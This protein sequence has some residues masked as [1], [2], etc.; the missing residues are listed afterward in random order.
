[1]ARVRVDPT[2]AEQADKVKR[3]LRSCEGMMHGTD[4][5][6]VGV[7]RA[8][9]YRRVHPWEVLHHPE[10]SAYVEVADLGVPDLAIRQAHCLTRRVKD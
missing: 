6:R 4:E 8:V 10:S 7:E 3:S 2:V 1:M 5:R 9:P